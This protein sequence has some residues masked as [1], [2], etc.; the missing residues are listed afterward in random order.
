MIVNSLIKKLYIGIECS[1]IHIGQFNLKNGCI[2]GSL[3]QS[4]C[5]YH[6]WKLSSGNPNIS[7]FALISDFIVRE[8]EGSTPDSDVVKYSRREA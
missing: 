8:K 4:K 2:N 7:D 3:A 5:L 6:F 1:G